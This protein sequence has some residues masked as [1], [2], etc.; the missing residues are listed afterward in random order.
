MKYTIKDDTNENE[1]EFSLYL[2][3]YDEAVGEVV[4]MAIDQN[5]RRWSLGIFTNNG[6]ELVG[7]I[8]LEG[9]PLSKGGYFR[10][11]KQA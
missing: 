7:R 5:G 6:L 3:P 2:E 1:P 8:Q 11:I 10:V 9:V 4:L